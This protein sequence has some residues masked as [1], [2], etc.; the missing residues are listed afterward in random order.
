MKFI[1]F[2]KGTA[3][4]LAL[5]L[6]LILASSAFASTKNNLQL[7]NPVVINEAVLKPG[8]YTVE[9]E[10]NG[11][12]VELSILQGTHLKAKVMAHLV[13][14]KAPAEKSEAIEQENVGKDNTLAGIE[15]QGKTTALELGAA[16]TS[17]GVLLVVNQGD[18]DLGIVDPRSAKQVERIVEGGTTGHEVAV[19]LDGKTAYVPIYGDSSVGEAGTDGRDMVAIDIASR[20]VVGHLDFGHGVR[21]HCAVMNPK[22]GLLYVTT[23]LDQTVTIIDPNKLQVVGVIPTGQEQSHML[24]ISHDGR[25]GYTANVSAGTVSVLDIPARKLITVIPVSTKVQRISISADDKWVF[26]ADQ[27]KPQLAVIDT[28]TNKVKTWIPIAAS[29]Y[30][31]ASTLDGRWLLI[32]VPDASQVSVVDLKTLQVVRTIP[33]PRVPH[34]IVISPDDKTAYV[35]CIRTKKVAAINLSDW[36]VKSVIEAGESVDGM[37]WA[38]GTR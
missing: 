24:V 2:L 30:G 1:T 32:C 9:W 37:A 35:S 5:V 19:S 11:P 33:V 14:L 26:T 7:N 29:G 34:E 8:N 28:A 17:T 36:S 3:L 13:E 25:F 21:P 4:S 18:A 12:N 23:E 20:K 31:T 27:A 38:A 6:A 15:F 10:G 16:S 22:D